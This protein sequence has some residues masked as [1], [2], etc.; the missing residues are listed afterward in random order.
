MVRICLVALILS[1]CAHNN[2][3]SDMQEVVPLEPPEAVIERE[4]QRR[5]RIFG[6]LSKTRDPR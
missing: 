5:E 3:A 2:C 4:K 6:V 1:G